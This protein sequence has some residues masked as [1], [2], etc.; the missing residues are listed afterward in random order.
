MNPI[1]QAIREE[2]EI[3]RRMRGLPLLQEPNR[4]TVTN[5]LDTLHPSARYYN[6]VPVP[7]PFQPSR[8]SRRQRPSD[9][10]DGYVGNNNRT[11]PR[12]DLGLPLLPN[13]ARTSRRQRPLSDP[14]GYVRRLLQPAADDNDDD[15]DDDNND[16]SAEDE[17]INVNPLPIQPHTPVRGPTLTSLLDALINVS[18]DW[19]EWSRAER[20]DFQN[21]FEI[22]RE[23]RQ[24]NNDREV[25]LLRHPEQNSLSDTSV[26]THVDGGPRTDPDNISIQS[27][28][29][30]EYEP[31]AE[32]VQRLAHHFAQ[33]ALA[34]ANSPHILRFRYPVSVNPFEIREEDLDE[35][36][37]VRQ[38]PP[39][40]NGASGL[41]GLIGAGL[42]SLFGAS[43]KMAT[44][45]AQR[46]NERK[47]K[48]KKEM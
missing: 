36:G 25:A 16:D 3:R 13:L 23:L 21:A 32:D 47:K 31:A 40:R 1:D 46:V 11:R 22:M 12:V 35:Y 2:M 43:G 7:P 30:D 19:N 27:D 26:Y 5:R 9:M 4:Q 8:V 45:A 6:A 48:S 10:D 41:F 24:A 44:R 39:P 33:E 42:K 15:D 18:E 38:N 28:E 20:D 37:D 17:D 29:Y 14:D 34:A